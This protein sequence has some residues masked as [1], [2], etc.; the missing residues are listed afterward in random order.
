MLYYRFHLQGLGLLLFIFGILVCLK[1]IWTFPGDIAGILAAYRSGD[2]DELLSSA[3]AT[4]FYWIFTA[5]LIWFSIIPVCR[6]FL[7]PLFSQA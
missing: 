1:T 7:A 6:A 4:L 2:R 5:A 3:G